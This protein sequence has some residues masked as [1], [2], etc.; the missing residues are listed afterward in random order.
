MPTKET[1]NGNNSKSKV[2]T[3]NNKKLKRKTVTFADDN[4]KEPLNKESGQN[5]NPTNK[6]NSESSKVKLSPRQKKIL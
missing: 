4:K 6:S 5:P 2:T 3:N 1:N